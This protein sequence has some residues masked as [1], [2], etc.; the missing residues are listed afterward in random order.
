MTNFELVDDYVAGKLSETAKAEFEKGLEAD[1]ALKSEVAMQ[2]A[3]VNGIRKARAAELKAMLNNVP[4]G[5]LVDGAS[6]GGGASLWSGWNPMRMAATVGAIAVIGTGLYF[7]LKGSESVIQ[8]IPGAEVPIDSLMPKENLEEPIIENKD[9]ESI[10]TKE[11]VVSAEKK[12]TTKK[13]NTTTPKVEVVDPSDEMLSDDKVEEGTTEVP[14]SGIS[15]STIQ[16]ERDAKN[17]QYSF[18]YQFWEGKLFLFG[19]FEDSLYEIL[20]VHG[21]NKAMFLFFKENFYF[22]DQSKEDVMPLAPIQDR[23]VIRKLKEFRSRK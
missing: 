18:H 3:I 14:K 10:E 20:E 9:E 6:V 5:S 1:P 13:Q 11:T 4:V 17:K 22:L 16:V 12:V 8:N 19:S 21:E 15:L 7:Y 23:S 2:Q